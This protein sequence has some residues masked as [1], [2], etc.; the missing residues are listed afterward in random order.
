MPSAAYWAG[1]GKALIALAGFNAYAL[2]IRRTKNE[3]K[4]NW[5]MTIIKDA[6]RDRPTAWARLV[7]CELRHER[8]PQEL[9]A[10]RLGDLCDCV[11]GTAWRNDRAHRSRPSPRCKLIED[12]V[13]SPADSSPV[14]EVLPYPCQSSRKDSWAVLLWGAFPP[15]GWPRRRANGGA[16]QQGRRPAPIALRGRAS[17]TAN[18]HARG[19]APHAFVAPCRRRHRCRYPVGMSCSHAPVAP[20]PTGIKGHSARCSSDMTQFMTACRPSAVGGGGGGRETVTRHD[21]RIRL[22]WLHPV[23]WPRMVRDS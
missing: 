5:P 22:Q 8:R 19:V 2:K 4:S 23:S 14:S 7:A 12:K 6:L 3:S 21:D 13:T 15:R 18:S 17:Y 20:Y 1:G 11:A 16:D 10:G 9:P